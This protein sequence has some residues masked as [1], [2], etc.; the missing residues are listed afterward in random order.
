MPSDERELLIEILQRVTAVETK[1]DTMTNTKDIAIE[2]LQSTK[3]AHHRLDQ[4]ESNQ[5][6]LWRTVIAA[7]ITGAIALFWKGING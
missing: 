2:A 7:L 3:S 4:V 1:V 6:W 5:T